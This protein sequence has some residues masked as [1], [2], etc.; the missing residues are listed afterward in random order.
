MPTVAP[1][2]AEDEG[3]EPIAPAAIAPATVVPAVTPAAVMPALAPA[4]IVPAVA[5]AAIVPAVVPTVAPPGQPLLG[6]DFQKGLV[7]VGH[8]AQ[9]A[10]DR[11]ADRLKT[12]G[13]RSRIPGIA[14]GH[15]RR[16]GVGCGEADRKAER[17]G[18]QQGCESPQRPT[19]LRHSG[20]PLN[21]PVR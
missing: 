15:G 17:S 6:I 7:A 9:G 21:R 10:G 11:V 16:L 3:Q 1:G 19:I 4:A 5:P 14:V 20:L 13:H 2:T 8:L 12:L 18:R